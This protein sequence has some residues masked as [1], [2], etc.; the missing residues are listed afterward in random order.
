[1]QRT[2][3]RAENLTPPLN[4][5]SPLRNVDIASEYQPYTHFA[6]NQISGLV[7]FQ[8]MPEPQKQCSKAQGF[9]IARDFIPTLPSPNSFGCL[10]GLILVSQHEFQNIL[11]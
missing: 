1:M 6:I 10:K 4:R 9:I 7:G 8:D 11:V 3:A 5:T 2:H